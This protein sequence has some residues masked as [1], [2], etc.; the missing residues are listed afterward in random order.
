MSELNNG[1]MSGSIMIVDDS[2][3]ALR[4]LTEL[5][6]E[7]GYE[8]RPVLLGRQAIKAAISTPPDL[9]LLDVMMPDMDGYE[10]CR[11]LKASPETKDIP[12]IFLTALDL[13]ENE[14][15][16]F[17]LGAV[18]YI[19]KPIQIA[20]VR[21]RVKT[22]IQLKLQRDQLELQTVELQAL[23][24]ELESF[25]H[26]VSHDLKAPLHIIKMYGEMIQKTFEREKDEQGYEEIQIILNAC[27]R[28]YRIID[29]LLKLST[30]SR[31]ELSQER[32]DLSALAE[33]S[34]QEIRKSQP[35]RTVEFICMPGL[36]TVADL[37]LIRI[38]IFDLLSN[39]WKYTSKHKTARI[40]FGAIQK[41]VALVFYVKDDG[42][43][44]DS[45][46]A[47]ELFAPFV[48]FHSESEFEG[49]GIG[50]SIVNRII[51]RHGGQIWAESKPEKGA[52]FWFTINGKHPMGVE[53]KG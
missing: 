46:N 23:N 12:I 3:D 24:S 14:E 13:E 41:G 29:D 26:S 38:A 9:I 21:A 2:P 19:S 6:K 52:T 7:E 36:M 40:E 35:E 48:R 28:T 17:A 5:L 25:G 27:A 51:M 53:K 20:I 47:T 18:D 32:V 42:A 11:K 49:T 43:G 8:V 1:R 45:E 39:A 37:N 16:G 4:V 10:V 22:H 33:T 44:F 30:I 34:F 15:T 50:L 31:A